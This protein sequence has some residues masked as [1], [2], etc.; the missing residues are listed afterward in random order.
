MNV[1]FCWNCWDQPLDHFEEET[2]AELL[3]SLVDWFK[4]Q[5]MLHASDDA[6]STVSVVMCDETGRSSL[7][8]L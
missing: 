5:F 4:F 3:T 7:N 2:K 6:R 8:T 1:L